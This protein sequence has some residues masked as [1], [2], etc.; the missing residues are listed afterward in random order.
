MLKHWGSAAR[1]WSVLLRDSG[2]GCSIA[3]QPARIEPAQPSG[4]RR[5]PSPCLSAGFWTMSPGC[6]FFARLA[7]DLQFFHTWVANKDL[8]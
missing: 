6:C 1:P 7:A 8:S 3:G 4:G 5:L 2:G